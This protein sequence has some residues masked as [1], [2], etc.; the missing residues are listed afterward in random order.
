MRKC[1]LF[2]YIILI[3]LSFNCYGLTIQADSATR[4]VHDDTS[5]V[6]NSTATTWN[7][8]TSSAGG[9]CIVL[10][11]QL[12]SIPAGKM[13]GEAEFNIYYN[14]R[15]ATRVGPKDSLYAIPYRTSSTITLSDYFEGVFCDDLT[16]AVAVEDDLVSF[17]TTGT[18]H[19]TGT[20][21]SFRLKDYIR[22]QY[23]DGAQSGDWIFMRVNSELEGYDLYSR[24]E[25]ASIYYNGGTVQNPSSYAPYIEYTLI[26]ENSFAAVE[27]TEIAELPELNT[28]LSSTLFTAPIEQ[29][30][31]FLSERERLG[32]KPRYAVNSV[33]FDSDNRPYMLE[34]NAVCTLNSSNKWIRLN[35][36]EELQDAFPDWDGTYTT[37]GAGSDDR[38]VF[39]DDDDAYV[40]LNLTD[41]GYVMMH[42]TDSC[43]NWDIIPLY[44]SSSAARIE[45]RDSYNDLSNPPSIVVRTLRDGVSSAI[46]LICPRKSSGMVSL[47]KLV[48]LTSSISILGGGLNAGKGGTNLSVTLGSKT[49]VV[50]AGRYTEGTDPG[51][52]QYAVTYDRSSDTV[53]SAFY[54]GS[55]GVGEPDEHNWPGISLDSSGYLNAIMGAHGG[56]SGQCFKYRKSTNVNSSSS[57]GTLTNLTSGFSYPSMICDYSNNLHLVAR[58]HWDTYVQKLKYIDKPSGQSWSTTKEELVVPYIDT[59]VSQTYN[60]Y[61]QIL[62]IDR[63][64]NLYLTYW[65]GSRVVIDDTV[66]ENAYLMKWPCEILYVTTEG[67]WT[68]ST[69]YDLHSPDARR[70]AIL[71]SKDGGSSWEIA[72]TD[73]FV[74]EINP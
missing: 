49:H 39:D 52:P 66:A 29:E 24:H 7:V 16:D 37:S 38:V 64:G 12:P 34:K 61:D 5:T 36:S 19:T 35:F 53:S 73:D 71:V 51:T 31:Y 21:G 69:M 17:D 68:S 63:N 18:W 72:V 67:E 45:Y 14:G 30:C 47:S 65:N 44:E 26:D 32:Y 25:Y 4:E 11:F 3:L 57:W 62:N 15:Y 58:D 13:I 40:L 48:R 46:D 33:Q 6:Y 23:D 9:R 54:L 42:S 22:K 50:F 1:G 10:A 27:T 70:G 59:T 2:V 43:R 60:R 56:A 28:S 41:I 8:L 74:S 55:A 20:F